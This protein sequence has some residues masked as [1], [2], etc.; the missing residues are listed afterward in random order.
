MY[1]IDFWIF[2]TLLINSVLHAR[3]VQ[4]L[5]EF[6]RIF[7]GIRGIGSIIRLHTPVSTERFFLTEIVLQT[8][9]LYFRA[10]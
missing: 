3:D 1:L 4:G 7:E 6:C 10:A 8:S 9:Q 2:S 5:A